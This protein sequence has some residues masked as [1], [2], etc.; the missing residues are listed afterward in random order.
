MLFGLRREASPAKR[1]QGVAVGRRGGMGP[2]ADVLFESQ[3]E[4]GWG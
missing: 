2:N 4:A 3:E 1:G